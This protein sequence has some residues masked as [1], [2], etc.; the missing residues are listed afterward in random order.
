MWTGGA[1]LAPKM[2]LGLGRLPCDG[3][4]S[5]KDHESL[6]EADEAMLLMSAEDGRGRAVSLWSMAEIDEIDETDET[7]ETET[8][9]MRKCWR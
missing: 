4:T 7:D 6:A 2:E 5:A 9:V 8:E 1:Q 3:G